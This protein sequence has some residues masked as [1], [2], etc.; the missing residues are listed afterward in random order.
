[1]RCQRRQGAGHPN[2]R[3]SKK[4]TQDGFMRTR[5][6]ETVKREERQDGWPLSC[7]L[8]CNPAEM[9]KGPELTS[10]VY[11]QGWKVVNYFIEEHGQKWKIATPRKGLRVLHARA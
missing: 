4:R 9:G 1:V 6:R 7:E 11:D 8:S 2:V 3:D 10:I 5:S